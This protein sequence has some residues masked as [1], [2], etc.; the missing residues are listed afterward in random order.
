MKLT[1]KNLKQTAYEVEVESDQI[2]VK[3]LKKV[4]EDTHHFDADK[5]KLLFAGAVLA[6]D[7]TLASYKI[8][9]SCVIIMMGSK[10]KVENIPKPEEHKENPQP[11]A[12]NPQP[13]AVN[14]QPA[15]SQSPFS[16][17]QPQVQPSVQPAAQQPK[18]AQKDYTNEV[19][20]LV[21]MGFMKSEAEAAV[22]AAR[23]NVSLAIEYLST[24]IP[25]NLPP[26]QPAGMP[27]GSGGMPAGLE[28][29]DPLRLVA[30]IIKV[31]C[32]Q[33]PDALQGLLMNIEQTDPQLMQMIRNREEEFRN[34]VSQPVT[35]EDIRMYQ[36]FSQQVLGAR[37]GAGMSGA[38]PHGGIP[39]GGMPGMAGARRPPHGGIQVTREEYEAIG[40]LKELGFSEAEA[41]QAY[42]AFDKNEEL[43][44]NFLF[45][46]KFADG[47]MN[48]NIV[49][50]PQP[51]SQPNPAQQPASQPNPAQQPPSQPNPNPS[52]PDQNA[53]QPQPGNEDEKMDEEKKD[54]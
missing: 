18:P 14:P 48:F 39:A 53:Q 33:N 24:G 37:G 42:M 22:R 5:L 26:E 12:V 21:E 7:N 43:A 25:E 30:S 1:I 51:A 41:A 20:Q 34:L 52:Q 38:M 27:S 28:Q 46:N 31:L 10:L 4:I 36:T 35:E 29:T 17:P 15:V 44:A 16:Q 40:R 49:D 3:Q 8:N 45:E 6:D 9:D 47:G 19:N 54:Q 11:A 23:G 32:S 13:A 2:T 50:N